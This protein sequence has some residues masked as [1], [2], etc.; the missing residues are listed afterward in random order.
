MDRSTPQAPA[1]ATMFAKDGCPYCVRAERILRSGGSDVR[2]IMVDELPE[3]LAR[4]RALSM[5]RRT[6]PQIFL[7]GEWI[8]GCDDLEALASADPD[9]LKALIARSAIGS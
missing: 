6:V 4:M 1:G 7:A 8:G 9:R 5:D 3:E 2:K